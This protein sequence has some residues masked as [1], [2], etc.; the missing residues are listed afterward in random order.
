MG[1]LAELGGQVSFIHGPECGGRLASSRFTAGLLSWFSGMVCH[2]LFVLPL[3][4][5]ASRVPC[6]VPLKTYCCC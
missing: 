1:G 6:G 4:P 3:A 5:A 2:T